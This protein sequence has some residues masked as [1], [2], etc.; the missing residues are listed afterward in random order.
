MQDVNV[1]DGHDDIVK[2]VWCC[3]SYL[4]EALPEK[5]ETESGIEEENQL[6]GRLLG[7]FARGKS[8]MSK[9]KVCSSSLTLF[10]NQAHTDRFSEK[11]RRSCSSMIIMAISKLSSDLINP[12]IVFYLAITLGTNLDRQV[13]VVQGT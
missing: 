6:N 10:G 5:R 11:S 8:G 3:S 12:F 7:L 4:K 1:G 13:S 2:A 9:L